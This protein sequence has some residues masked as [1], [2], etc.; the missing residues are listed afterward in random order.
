MDNVRTCTGWGLA[1]AA[2]VLSPI[3]VIF[4]IP[5]TI[6]IGLDIFEL[7][8]EVPFVLALCATAAFVVFRL[9][10]PRP[11]FRQLA[12]ACCG[13]RLIARPG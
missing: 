7:I 12:A 10:S 8:G 11:L 3:A 2:V 9:V 1:I 13:R 6:G 5:L 4:L